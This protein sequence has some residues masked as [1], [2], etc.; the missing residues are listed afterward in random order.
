M[1]RS[2]LNSL[3]DDY[4]LAFADDMLHFKETGV[5]CTKSTNKALEILNSHLDNLFKTYDDWG[6]REETIGFLLNHHK[7]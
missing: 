6:T 4:A 5:Y 3:I 2:E 7:E 1:D